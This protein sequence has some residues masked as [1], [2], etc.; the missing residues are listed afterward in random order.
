MES[1]GRVELSGRATVVIDAV[2]VSGA[3]AVIS[4]MAQFEAKIEL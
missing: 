4:H 3:A 2:P 1:G